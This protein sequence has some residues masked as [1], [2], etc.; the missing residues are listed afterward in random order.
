MA[1][2][3]GRIVGHIDLPRGEADDAAPA[4]WSGREGVSSAAAAVV[5][6]P[7]VAPA[8]RGHRI[9]AL[10][11]EREARERA[12][13]PVLDVVASGTSAVALYERLGRERLATVE[14]RWSPEHTVTVHCY[15]AAG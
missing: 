8:A 14:Q 11:M 5:G 13:H 3:D 6:R 1:E 7:F 2:L 10:L 12:P 15:A 4:L 9:G